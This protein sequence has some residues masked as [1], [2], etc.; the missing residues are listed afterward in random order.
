MLNAASSQ[1]IHA[2][3]HEIHQAI[4]QNTQ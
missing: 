3:F 2:S 4:Q 1:M